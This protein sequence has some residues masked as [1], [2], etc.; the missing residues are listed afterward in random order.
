VAHIRRHFPFFSN[1]DGYFLSYQLGLMKPAAGIYETVE[2]ATGCRGPE[3]L[4]LDDHEPNVAAGVARGWRA[5]RHTSPA[6]TIPVVERA[7]GL[8]QA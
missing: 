7:L 5:L 1:F 8:P 2:R 3:I 4:Y 6:E